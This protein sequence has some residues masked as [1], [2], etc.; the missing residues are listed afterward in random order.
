M[1]SPTH[2]SWVRGH[3]SLSRT[4][5]TVIKCLNV[6]IKNKV[7]TVWNRNC[8]G[9]TPTWYLWHAKVCKR[10][11]LL[12]IRA[13][14]RVKRWSKVSGGRATDMQNVFCDPMKATFITECSA[15]R[16][17]GTN[18]DISKPSCCIY[19]FFNYYYSMQDRKWYSACFYL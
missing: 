18:S 11:N 10:N 16:R 9:T 7:M 6:V 8:C 15:M 17:R 1:T 2:S 3:I 5:Y 4:L 12:L 13:S 19:A 14:S